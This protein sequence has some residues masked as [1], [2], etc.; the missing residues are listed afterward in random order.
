MA[1]TLQTSDEE[2]RDIV[3]EAV[4]AAFRDVGIIAHDDDSVI[5]RRRDFE[6][7]HDLRTSTEGV[8]SKAGVTLLVL[9]IG[10][11]ATWVVTGLKIWARQ[12]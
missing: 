8:K 3:K 10:G 4:S 6:F 11:L 9:S 5:K 1:K 12:P 7:L 2:L